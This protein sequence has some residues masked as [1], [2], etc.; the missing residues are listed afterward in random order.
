MYGRQTILSENITTFL[1]VQ[2][3]CENVSHFAII[4]T[5]LE[6]FK[7][8]LEQLY[9]YIYETVGKLRKKNHRFI[10]QKYYYYNKF[11]QFKKIIQEK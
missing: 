5:I 11:K 3:V 1:C 6:L 4:R 10:W 8:Y 2:G 9:I 7:L